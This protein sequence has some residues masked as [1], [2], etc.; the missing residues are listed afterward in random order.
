M[1]VARR[2]LPLSRESRVQAMNQ[3]L[4]RAQ[5][6]AQRAAQAIVDEIR[7]LLAGH[8]EGVD[9]DILSASCDTSSTMTN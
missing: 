4:E 3:E 9:D 7:K 5:A 6:D 1:P 8:Y 2:R